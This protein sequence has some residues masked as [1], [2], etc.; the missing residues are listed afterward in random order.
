MTREKDTILSDLLCDVKGRLWQEKEIEDIVNSKRNVS[1]TKWMWQIKHLQS[2]NSILYCPLKLLFV[3][4]EIEDVNTDFTN[5]KASHNLA[6]WSCMSTNKLPTYTKNV[7]P[8][9]PMVV[10]VH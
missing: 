4:K 9:K 7:G 10:A 2:K 8:Y 1:T 6:T 5:F 3:A